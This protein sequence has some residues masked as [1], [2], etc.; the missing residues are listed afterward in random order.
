M[1][2]RIRRLVLWLALGATGLG[3]GVVVYWWVEVRFTHSI[4]RDA[5]VDSHLVNIAPQ[6]AGVIVEE[7]V[8]EQ[9]HVVAGQL[10]ALID[11]SVYRSETEL[12]RAKVVVAEAALRK[13]EADLALLVE[14]VPQRIRIA[15]R[16]LDISREDEVKAKDAL[17]LTVRDVEKG[18][19]AASARLQKM[20]AV[21]TLAEEDYR[22]YRDL[23]QERSVSE[24]RY[25]EATQS[26]ASA[27]AEVAEAEARL[28]QA[29]AGRKQ[30]GIME[31]Q[32]FAARHAIGEA[33]AAF[34]L[35]Q[36]GDLQITVGR[37]AVA[38]R[39]STVEQA[40]R[41]LALAE[42]NLGYTR[43][44]A[45]SDG[46]I[47]KKWRYRGD[48]ARPGDPIVNVYNPE[49]LYVTASLEETLLHGVAPGNLARL[50]VDA[51]R[52]PF[53]GR[54]L[55]IGSATDANF[56]LIPRDVSSGEFTYV[57]QRVPVRLNF[58]PDD[59]RK[60]LK[61]GLSVRVIID[62]GLGDAT[63]AA[64]ALRRQAEISG[65]REGRP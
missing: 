43:V 49:L 40:R 59:R 25:Q 26:H 54:V 22:R 19:D 2:H 24:R 34:R 6:V 21:F 7:Y 9:D 5:F 47:A 11:P 64:E 13:A 48:Y 46:V 50:E 30:V 28:G 61:P 1:R 8:Q 42:T 57:V 37:Q 3:V 32:L 10:L 39:A 16:K 35:A 44:L 63:W 14:E 36:A 58:E 12:A 20:R 38:E 65:V 45:P 15:Q 52:G 41:A 31:R 33:E 55:W 18:I 51:I 53:T 27:R 23:F 62:H 17:E 56:S 4:T 60:L 29:E